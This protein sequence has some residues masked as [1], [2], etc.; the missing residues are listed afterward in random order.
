MRVAKLSLLPVALVLP[1]IAEGSGADRSAPPNA[2]MIAVIE[3]ALALPPGSRPLITYVRYYGFERVGPSSTKRLIIRGLL[4]QA[5]LN[6]GRLNRRPGA[7]G[8]K[9]VPYSPIMDGGCQV[10]HVYFDPA[11]QKVL[12]TMCNG[13]A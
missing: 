9:S 13:E 11:R 8:L 7:Y 10:V 1:T 12:R 6:M 4:V 3:K 5:G 2:Q